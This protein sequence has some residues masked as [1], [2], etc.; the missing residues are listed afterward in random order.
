MPTNCLKNSDWCKKEFAKTDLG[1]LRL[2]RRL[3]SL[4]QDFNENINKSIY[5]ATKDYNS[6]KAAYRF[7][8]NPR[9]NAEDI[10]EPHFERTAERMKEEDAVLA[11]HDSVVL[12]FTNHKKMQGLGTIG[13]H[14]I[15][16]GLLAH[17]ALITSL[18]GSALGL[19]SQEVI[20]R[21]STGKR[22]Y[23]RKIPI[24][25]KESIRWLTGLRKVEKRSPKSTTVIHVADREADFYEFINEAN[26]LKANYIIRGNWD[27]KLANC[28]ESVLEVL[29]KQSIATTINVYLESNGTRKARTAQCE[30]KFAAI[31]IRPPQYTGSLKNAAVYV[32]LVKENNPPQGIQGV[33][34]MLLTNLTVDCTEDALKII[35]Y[36]KVRWRIEEWHKILKSGCKAEDIQLETKERFDKYFSIVSVISVRLLWITYA[37]REYPKAS[38]EIFLTKA[39]WHTLYILTKRS[40]PPRNMKPFSLKEAA[41]RIAVLGGYRKNN[42]NSSPGITVI[43]R[44]WQTLQNAMNFREAFNDANMLKI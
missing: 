18:K 14:P 16:K 3:A 7:F 41:E 29:K 32:V 1:D 10:L 43:W 23:Y 13:G 33:E 8:N 25:E 34:W 39:E 42:S 24:E 5:S 15:N 11:I 2:N 12:E 36:Y 21:K 37:A 40:K 17:N 28:S 22:A 38:C 4:A 30:V 6:S 31:L 9:F 20:T 44:G 27:R 26:E 19:L 35:D